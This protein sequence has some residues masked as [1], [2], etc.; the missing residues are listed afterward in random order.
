MV[1][2]L[3]PFDSNNKFML[4][5]TNRRIEVILEAHKDMRDD[6]GLVEEDGGGGIEEMEVV[7]IL[8]RENLEFVWQIVRLWNT[9]WG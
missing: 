4:T 3:F 6:V 9:L 5:E 7:L 1:L 8:F 2:L